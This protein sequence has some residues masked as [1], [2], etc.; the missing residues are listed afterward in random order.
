MIIGIFLVFCFF[1]LQSFWMH[2]TLIIVFYVQ[3]CYC[4]A[5]PTSAAH[6]Y[7]CL[8]RK[9]Q[10]Q[11]DM[12]ISFFWFHVLFFFKYSSK[13]SNKKRLWNM[14]LFFPIHFLRGSTIMTLHSLSSG[15]PGLQILSFWIQT[16]KTM[17]W[18]HYPFIFLICMVLLMVKF[19]TQYPFCLVCSSKACTNFGWISAAVPRIKQ[20]VARLSGSYRIRK[21]KHL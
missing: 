18:A 7:K 1:V 12:S 10:F 21:A 11:L 8:L 20:L 16:I 15:I 17:F 5:L 4:K 14:F 19:S 6:L 3:V 2:I 13:R 9:K